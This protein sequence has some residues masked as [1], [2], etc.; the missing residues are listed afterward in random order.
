MTA[1]QEF[2]LKKTLEEIRTVR[3]MLNDIMFRTDTLSHDEYGKVMD[4]CDKIRE[5]EDILQQMRTDNK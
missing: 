4:A 2:I 1:R 3:M 5:S